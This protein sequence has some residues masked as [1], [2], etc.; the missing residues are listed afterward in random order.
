MIYL[1][2]YER[3]G[4]TLLGF[5]PD[6]VSYQL[7]VEF[8]DIG[9]ISFD[10]PVSGVNANLLTEFREVAVF[11]ATGNEYTNTRYVITNINRDRANADGFISVTGRGVLSRLE[12]ALA[13]PDGGVSSGS[14]TRYFNNKNAG[15]I[16]RTL[17]D[18]AQG[19][20]ALTGLNCGDFSTTT[21]ANSAA[22]SETV[23]QEYPA[24]N[25]ILSVLRSLQEYGIV[26]VQTIGT[27]IK[28]TNSDGIGT[29][30][31]TGLNPIVLRYGQNLTEAPEQRSA[32]RVATVALVEGDGGLMVERTNSAGVSAY[33]RIET[34]FTASGTDDT[35]TANALGD[36]YLGNLATTARQLTV[37]LTLA[38]D[39]PRPL[40][41][42]NVGDY[43][44]T[45]TA[46]G[47]E[48]VRVRQI[49]VSM[50][51][52]SLTASATLGDRIYE[53]EIRTS[54][55]L[56]AISS[57]SVA[58]GNGNLIAPTVDVTVTEDTVAPSPP[59]SLTGSTAAY[60]EGVDPYASV[61]LTWTAPTT[62][63]D[64]TALDDLDFYEV[65]I[66]TGSTDA[67][68][69]EANAD[70]NSAKIS[71]L[72]VATSYRFRVFA[73]DNS[74]NRSTASNE[75]VLTA[76]NIT[77][78]TGLTPSAPTATSRLGAISVTW[79]GLS[80]TGS[81]M[82]AD[83]SY[84][85]VHV[86]TTNNFTP[87]AGTYKGR[88]TGADTIVFSDLVY[89]TT[90]YVKFVAYNKSGVASAATAQTSVLVARLVDTDLIANQWTTWPFNGAVVSA[91]ALQSGSVD[92]TK[93][94]DGA[95]VQA[96]IAANAIGANQIAANAVVAG[97]LAAGAVTAGTIAALAI[98]AGD[99]S[100]N[101]ITADKIQAGAINASKIEAGSI[102]ATQ[103]SSS[104]VYA[105]TI[106]ANNIT[107][108]TITAS[109]AFNAASG[110][111]TGAVRATSGYIGSESAG[112]NFTSSGFIRNFDG[113]TVLYPTS[114]SNT[115]VMITDRAISANGFQS[116]GNILTTGSGKVTAQGTSANRCEFAYYNTI[117]LHSISS[118][119]GVDSDWSPN[120][121]NTY[122]LGQ[123]T[124]AG[125]FA[126]RRWQRL[127]ANNTT[128]STS[129]AR[130]KTD[131]S[132]SPLGLDFIESL[133]PVKYRWKVGRQEVALDENGE[134]TIVGESPEGKPIFEMVEHPGQRLHY[135]FIAQEVKEALDASGVEDFAGWVQDDINDPESTQSL[136][137]EQF[138]A[139][140]VKA[141]QELTA[142]VKTLEASA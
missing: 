24:R 7:G 136:S 57:G 96:K 101:A 130:L 21:D 40:E 73:V 5:L 72:T 125:A 134:A 107:A 126:N 17:I 106:S 76:S 50:S 89:G 33:G 30:R 100:A 53:N 59:T 82:P 39:A 105:G 114:G 62:N 46:A 137:Y 94:V 43:V 133:R 110:T 22:W 121:D 79:N 34:S 25:T 141:V 6:P 15:Y 117:L 56:A 28:A 23:T 135:G 19:R 86:S 118:G 14:L 26:E 85:A 16:L 102:T 120:S 37:G 51:G 81:A 115:Y 4:A 29:D 87:G 41:D 8:N 35:A 75:Y 64:A 49:T 27:S 13:Y 123:A 78:A 129:D 63:A 139:P 127:F 103:I 104:Y 98:Q 84:V 80:S 122:S 138:I 32:D 55:K 108:G 69:F 93:L 111:F 3:N 99:I 60:V 113:T 42:F 12:T 109:V 116:S 67:W 70:T 74:G 140:L 9:A 52:G 1:R 132:T 47:L 119:Y 83:F 44:Y 36:T 128:I 71:G 124:S 77:S 38:D 2:L 90:Y 97:K 45:A 95:V 68:E 92:A 48:R 11:D 142:R 61:S 112:W 58:L 91:T 66:R 131:I 18:A 54:R 88:M 65:Q 31:T 20:G 10:Y